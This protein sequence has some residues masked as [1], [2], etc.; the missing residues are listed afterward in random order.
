MKAEAIRNHY[1]KKELSK[2]GLGK[3]SS[4]NVW[5][6]RTELL[7]VDSAFRAPYPNMDDVSDEDLR[8]Y[9]VQRRKQTQEALER[10]RQ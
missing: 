1:R 8:M 7:P 2:Y 10:E 9:Q 3:P 6:A 4:E 5:E